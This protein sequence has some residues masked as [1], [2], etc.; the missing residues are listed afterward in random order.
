MSVIN[1]ISSLNKFYEYLQLHDKRNLSMII[2]LRIT[3][4][5]DMQ[6]NLKFD[7]AMDYYD[8][9]ELKTFFESEL[10]ELI[11]YFVFNMDLNCFL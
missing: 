3:D 6:R 5:I 10:R 2:G 7:I 4:P 1:Y 8:S 11:P 9:N